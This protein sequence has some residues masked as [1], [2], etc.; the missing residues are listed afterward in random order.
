M[1]VCMYVR[2]Y[3]YMYTFA[4][5]SQIY[6]FLSTYAKDNQFKVFLCFRYNQNNQNKCRNTLVRY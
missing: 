1:Y 5:T 3:V 4:Y 2:I 6:K